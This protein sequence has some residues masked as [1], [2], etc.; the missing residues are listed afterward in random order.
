MAG[1]AVRR[2]AAVIHFRQVLAAGVV[3]RAREAD[4]CHDRVLDQ[5]TRQL[6]EP[7]QD[8]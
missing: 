4:L 6:G 1:R 5:F 2:I 7:E 8:V 3:Q